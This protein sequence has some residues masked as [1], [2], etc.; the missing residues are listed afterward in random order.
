MIIFIL[1]YLLSVYISIKF[2]TSIFQ[3]IYLKLIFN[4]D[5]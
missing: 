1:T 4:F 5:I 2:T 3:L